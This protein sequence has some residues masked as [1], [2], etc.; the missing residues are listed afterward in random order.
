MEYVNEMAGVRS[1][2]I[3][4]DFVTSVDE[5]SLYVDEATERCL[6]DM[7]NK[8]RLMESKYYQ[9]TGRKLV[10]TESVGQSL[11]KFKDFIIAK[12][13]K[14]W[15][16]IQAAWKKV[17]DTIKGLCDKISGLFKSN[18]EI[19]VL[20]Q[21]Y[22]GDTS[23]KIGKYHEY[24]NLPDLVSNSGSYA[25]LI[26]KC[27]GNMKDFER[28]NINSSKYGIKQSIN[29]NTKL[30][31]SDALHGSYDVLN[32]ILG[33]EGKAKATEDLVKKTIGA[34]TDITIKDLQNRFDE[35]IKVGTDYSYNSKHAKTMYDDQKRQCNTSVKNVKALKYVDPKPF[36][37]AVGKI[38]T[39]MTILTNAATRALAQQN[40]EAGKLLMAGRKLVLHGNGAKETKNE[41]AMYGY[42]PMDRLFAE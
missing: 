4:P 35:F 13:K 33:S 26:E 1:A 23:E 42:D 39:A 40:R 3:I 41:S 37:L 11:E 27:I 34:E 8:V 18:R 25:K 21:K 36:S 5:A 2:N 17:L 10:Y 6:A 12:I 15:S 16:F 24:K 29:T 38:T 7:D 20:I 14:V 9:R 32:P 19:G 31:K 28:M 30:N 22:K